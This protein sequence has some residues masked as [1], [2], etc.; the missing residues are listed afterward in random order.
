MWDLGFGILR[1]QRAERLEFDSALSR[2]GA[3]GA[4]NSDHHEQV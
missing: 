3:A 1:A 2:G 4:H